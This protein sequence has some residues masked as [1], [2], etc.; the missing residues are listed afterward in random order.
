M[1]TIKWRE[2]SHLVLK[3][4]HGGFSIKRTYGFVQRVLARDQ[5]A[6]SAQEGERSRDREVA[7]STEVGG[8]H[9]VVSEPLFVCRLVGRGR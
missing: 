5:R 2:I 7:D 6:I 1:M 4:S 3:F 9:Q 8:L